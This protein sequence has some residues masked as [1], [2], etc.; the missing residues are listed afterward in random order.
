MGGVSGGRRRGADRVAQRRLT[1]WEGAGELGR[2]LPAEPRMRSSVVVIGTPAT[3]QH[4]SLGERGEQRLVQEI[5]AQTPIERLDEGVL[6][7]LSQR[8]VVPLDP[9]LVGPTQ[10]RVAGEL[11]SPAFGSVPLSL[12]IICGLP[13]AA[14][15]RS[16]SVATRRPES[17]VSAIRAMFSR[18]QSSTTVR[19]RKRRPSVS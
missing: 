4:A 2:C 14:I 10:D 11:A 15:N 6:D 5:V 17:D 16:S 9:G 8:D 18:V 12:T 1:T 3:E 7:R 13:R 19:M